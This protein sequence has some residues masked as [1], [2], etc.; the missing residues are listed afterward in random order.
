MPEVKAEVNEA[1][2]EAKPAAKTEDK[3]EVKAE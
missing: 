3:P 1:K 2:T